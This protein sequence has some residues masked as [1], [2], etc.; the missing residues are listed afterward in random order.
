LILSETKTLRHLFKNY[1]VFFDYRNKEDIANKIR[2]GIESEINDA[3]IGNLRDMTKTT[4]NTSIH[5]YTT[6]IESSRLA[7]ASL[8]MLQLR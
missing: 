5:I 6:K 1:A 4:S 2:I 7:S 8:L 3:E